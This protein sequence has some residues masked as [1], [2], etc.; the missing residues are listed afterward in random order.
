ML[1]R[2]VV[3]LT[4]LCTAGCATVPHNAMLPTVAYPFNQQVLE[5]ADVASCSDEVL[6]L[7]MYG[8]SKFERA[9]FLL[10]DETGRFDCHVWP[11]DFQFHKAQW[12]GRTPDGT[13]ALIHSHPQN[14]PDPSLQ[15]IMEAMR[16]GVP[17]IVVT[18]AAT[19][20]AMPGDGRVIRVRRVSG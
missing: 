6:S 3:L 4:I 10:I 18:P 9:A 1:E 17:V 16:L 7:G 19:A 11:A 2:T 8:R 15:D 20:M 14:F 12:R 5:R 13:A